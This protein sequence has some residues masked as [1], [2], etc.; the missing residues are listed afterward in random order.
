MNI[1]QLFRFGEYVIYFWSNEGDPSEPIH[2]HIS[3][4]R[5]SKGGTKIWITRS[6]KALLA[7]NDSRVPDR[8]LNI[9]VRFIEANSK[10]IINKW[11]EQFGKVT[12]YC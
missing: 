5:P 9:F 10:S 8:K 2:V 12:Y 3:S 6:G 11:E 4:G 1:P 7:N